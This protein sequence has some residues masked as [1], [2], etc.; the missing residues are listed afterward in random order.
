MKVILETYRNADLCE[1]TSLFLTYRDLRE[2]FTLIDQAEDAAE[3]TARP[4]LPWM[5]CWLCNWL[6]LLLG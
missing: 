5:R 4:G 6:A 2:Q 1:R 3:E